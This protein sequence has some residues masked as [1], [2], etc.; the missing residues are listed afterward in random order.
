V[1]CSSA[2]RQHFRL[3][4]YSGDDFD[5]EATG[6]NAGGFSGAHFH[7]T[8]ARVSLTPPTPSRQS[9]RLDAHGGVNAL[10]VIDE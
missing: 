9:A 5:F 7:G 10:I 1:V 2:N 8:H 4:H 3:H 6:E